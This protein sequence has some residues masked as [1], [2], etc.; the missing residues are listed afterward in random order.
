MN[1]KRIDALL[2]AYCVENAQQCYS[3]NTEKGNITAGLWLSKATAMLK[4]M[5]NAEGIADVVIQIQKLT[6]QMRNPNGN[7]LKN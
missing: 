3:E 5:P 6:I 7:Y 1:E 4:S 2:A